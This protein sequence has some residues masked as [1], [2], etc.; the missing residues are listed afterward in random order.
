MFSRR[1]TLIYPLE[2]TKTRLALSTTGEFGTVFD[3]IG[4][5]VKDGGECMVG[6]S[7]S[8]L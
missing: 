4:S 1:Q 7:G 3:V 6:L 2:I 5:I 8:W